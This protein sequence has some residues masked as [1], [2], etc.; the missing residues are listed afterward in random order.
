[1]F[2]TELMPLIQHRPLTITVAAFGDKQIRV[3]VVPQ[4]TEK[5]KKPNQQIGYSHNK[6]VAAIP[7][8]AMQGLTTPLC[9]TGT[10]EEVDAELTNT[11][12]KFT[13][14]HV[15]LQQSF[16]NAATAIKEAVKAIDE[17]ERIKKE[18]DKANS[19]KQTPPKAEEKKPAE[20]AGLPLLFT[21]Q[22]QNP[23]A[24]ASAKDSAP[25]AQQ[26]PAVTGESP[27]DHDGDGEE[28]EQETKQE[29]SQP[30]R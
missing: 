5:D 21:T 25:P 30:W 14:L 2:F 22:G 11:L 8:E 1:M 24:A 15:G 23:R 10:A 16:D 29:E 26:G 4:A 9:L 13:S 19:K 18:K 6:E 17:R 20:E 28:E 7:D 27:D 12:T 3:N